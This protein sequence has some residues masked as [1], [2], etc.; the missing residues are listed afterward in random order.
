MR[1]QLSQLKSRAAVSQQISC[2]ACNT[3]QAHCAAGWLIDLDIDV[4]IHELSRHGLRS[5]CTEPFS[6]FP[7]LPADW[8]NRS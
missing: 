8:T 4:L 1:W 2:A 5:L 3:K 6:C 7:R